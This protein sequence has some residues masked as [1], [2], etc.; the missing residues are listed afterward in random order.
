VSDSRIDN[1][2]LDKVETQRKN[3]D[4]Q[5]FVESCWRLDDLSIKLWFIFIIQYAPILNIL[6]R[7]A[8]RIN[9]GWWMVVGRIKSTSSA[10]ILPVFLSM[11]YPRIFFGTLVSK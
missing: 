5:L 1:A 2:I 11:S 9:N 10:V 7:W 8:V 4:Y 6:A 3:I